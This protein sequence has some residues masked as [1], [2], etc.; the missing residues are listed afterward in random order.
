MIEIPISTF[1][2]WT[3][4]VGEWLLVYCVAAPLVAIAAWVA[5]FMTYEQTFYKKPP[6]WL[7]AW[8]FCILLAFS[9]ILAL[10][11][12]GVIVWA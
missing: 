6:F 8:S 9:Q 11:L 2:E 7:A 5:F 12:R 3:Q 1:W 4:P 10:S